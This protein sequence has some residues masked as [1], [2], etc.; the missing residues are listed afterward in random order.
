MLVERGPYCVQRYNAFMAI[1]TPEQAFRR[2]IR[3][4]WLE[5]S[6]QVKTLLRDDNEEPRHQ[7]FILEL[8]YG[9][10]LLITRNLDQGKRIPLNVGDNV[11]VRGEYKW[12]V[13][14]GLIHWTHYDTD[15]PG[16]G[17]WIELTERG[18]K[19]N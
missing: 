12:D 16:N 13:R 7:R 19:Y 11:R 10:T 8:P 6:G 1:I 2:Q 9:H 14:G 5:T 3:R 15:E 4:V 17:G 18:E